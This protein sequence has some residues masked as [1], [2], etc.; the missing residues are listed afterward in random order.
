MHTSRR[1]C[2]QFVLEAT[3]ERVR[4]FISTLPIRK[5]PGVGKVRAGY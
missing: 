3:H 5:V 1:P 2:L 4:A